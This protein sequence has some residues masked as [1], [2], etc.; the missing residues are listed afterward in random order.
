MTSDLEHLIK[1]RIHAHGVISVGEYMSLCLAHPEHGY[2]MKK[3]PF[4]ASG[5]FITA[6]EIS[7]MF[8]EMIGVWVADMWMQMGAP[9][10]FILLE[11]GPGRGTLMGDILRAVR[12]VN[13]FYDAAKIHLM[14]ISPY[15]KNLQKN[16]LSDYQVEWI[17][18]VEDLPVDLPIIA[19]GNE[20]LDA[21][22][23]TSIVQQKGQWKERV[24][25]LN[26]SDAFDFGVRE[27]C[28][29]Y[30]IPL[31]KMIESD[32]VI[33]EYS[34]ERE[35]FIHA[36]SQCIFASGGAGLMIDYGHE[37]S[38][39]GDTFQALKNNSYIDVFE[40]CGDADLTSHVDFEALKNAL[41]EG[42]KRSKIVRQGDFLRA[43]GIVHRAEALMQRAD[44]KQRGDIQKSLNRLCASD[45]MGKLFKAFCFYKDDE[46]KI[47]PHGF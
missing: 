10:D 21:L 17:G 23:F 27:W 47:N 13:G 14:E 1:D 3:D 2:Y 34:K 22:P 8:G 33:F 26:E 5:D 43:L 30:D 29:D 35:A 24:I 40:E 37:K 6:P 9:G 32:G 38:A 31:K 41:P 28:Q 19:I 15:L 39:I 20:F 45:Q 4:G 25:E 11:C 16:A 12:G 44:E 36:L 46:G 42:V 18:G 7:Q